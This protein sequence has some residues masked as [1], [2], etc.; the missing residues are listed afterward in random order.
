[1]RT[2]LA[3]GAIAALATSASAQIASQP[4]DGITDG[5]VISEATPGGFFDNR[6]ADNFNVSTASFIDGVSWWG[7][8]EGFFS[9]DFPGNIASFEI[10]F[11]NDNAGSPGSVASSTTVSIADANLS[12]TDT[13]S[14]SFNGGDIFR[15]DFVFDTTPELPAGDYWLSIGA[16]PV[17]DF[18]DD[19]SFFWAYSG[20]GDGTL[21]QVTPA[22]GSGW[23]VAP[24]TDPGGLSN[25]LALEV[26]ATPVPAPGAFALVGLAGLAGARRRR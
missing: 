15:F 22:D 4:F 21:A 7:T 14:D 26:F 6:G 11:L 20:T 3:L 8:E 19:D 2:A 17:T 5:F 18:L 10:S 16:N 25:G 1:M 12:A 24:G 9:I 13:G 23:V